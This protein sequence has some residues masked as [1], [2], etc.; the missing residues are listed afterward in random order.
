M[1]RTPGAPSISTDFRFTIR[2]LPKTLPDSKLILILIVLLNFLKDIGE[3]LPTVA[4]VRNVQLLPFTIDLEY[5]SQGN[6]NALEPSVTVT[7]DITAFN[8]V[9]K[10][11]TMVHRNVNI[12]AD[13]IDSK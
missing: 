1:L 2:R 9:P 10:G 4:S 5:A 11:A 13:D 3:F 12:I 8:T 7:Y 6:G